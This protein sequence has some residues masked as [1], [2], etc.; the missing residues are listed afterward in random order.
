MNRRPTLVLAAAAGALLASA[1]LPTAVAFADTAPNGSDPFSDFATQVGSNLTGVSQLDDSLYAADPDLA[2]ALDASVTSGQV[3]FGIGEAPAGDDPFTQLLPADATTAQMNA[4]ANFDAFLSNGDLTSSGYPGAHVAGDPTL[5][6][7][8]ATDAGNLTS[9]G[10]GGEGGTGPLDTPGSDAFTIGNYTFDPF[11]TD[12]TEGFDPLTQGTGVPPFFETGSVS[13]Q[14]FEIFSAASSSGTGGSTAPDATE[15]QAVLSGD[16]VST[17]DFSGNTT[18]SDVATALANGTGTDVFGGNVTEAQVTAALGSNISF[19][20]GSTVSAA[21]IAADLNNATAISSGT[22]LGTITT[23]E[24]VTSLFGTTDTGFT[25]TSVDPAEGVDASQLPAEGTV[26]NVAD[27][28][29]LAENV[30]IDIPGTGGAADTVKDVLIT[31]FGNFDLS[32]LVQAF[33]LSALNP[34]APFGIAV[35]TG[36]S[37]ATDTTTAVAGDPLS[38]LGL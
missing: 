9:G 14:Q 28:N 19:A 38:F 35:D 23:N 29:G 26:Y 36:T 30:Y 7:T 22:E 18:L 31:P 8:L 20:D 12:G 15:I 4:A 25:I 27:F 1:A 13:G 2:A 17:A 5:A 16:N 34:G 33:D 37:T 3:P 10:G 11:T 24:N 32:S 21:D 6:A